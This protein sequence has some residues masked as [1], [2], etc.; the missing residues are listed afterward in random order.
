[1]IPA[2]YEMPV[3]APS[4]LRSQPVLGTTRIAEVYHKTAVRI[5]EVNE[6]GV[7]GPGTCRDPPLVGTGGTA[8]C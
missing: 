3:R 6:E 2:K 7:V 5:S 1:M 8:T 4:H